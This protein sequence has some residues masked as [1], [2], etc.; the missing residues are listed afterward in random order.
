MGPL[1]I[2]AASSTVVASSPALMSVSEG[3]PVDSRKRET[4]AE[5]LDLL[6][7]ACVVR[8]EDTSSAVSSA[9]GRCLAQLVGALNI[10]ST[11]A[12]DA[13]ELLQRRLEEHMLF[14]QFVFPFTAL[15]HRREDSALLK[16]R[17]EICRAHFAS[18]K[19]NLSAASS[20]SAPSNNSSGV[21]PP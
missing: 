10:S 11:A 14:E 7:V 18:A 20:A 5:S 4:F 6:L 15:V 17:L 3:Y 19:C 2:S 13:Q 8:L 1:D 12:A 16:R 9:A 21:T